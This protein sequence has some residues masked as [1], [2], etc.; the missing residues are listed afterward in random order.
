MAKKLLIVEDDPIIATDMELF[1][2]DSG[3]NVVAVAHN[4][5]TAISAIEGNRPDIA[6]LDYQLGKENSLAIAET[7]DN[8]NIPFC[9]LTASSS[10]QIGY[11]NSPDTPIFSKPVRY[12][13][14]LAHIAK[15][16]T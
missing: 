7:L 13:L 2:S 10:A 8:M 16:F 4:V 5:E 14:V 15:Y 9:F 12:E 11:A 3:F 1:F 6:L